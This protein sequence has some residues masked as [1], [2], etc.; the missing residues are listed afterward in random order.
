[1][2]CWDFFFCE[3]LKP[4]E[5]VGSKVIKRAMIGFDST[6]LLRAYSPLHSKRKTRTKH[7]RAFTLSRKAVDVSPEKLMVSATHR[8]TC[9]LAVIKPFF[10]LLTYQIDVRN[11]RQRLRASIHCCTANVIY[12]VVPSIYIYPDTYLQPRR[13]L[14]CTRER[15]CHNRGA[16]LPPLQACAHVHNHFSESRLSNGTRA[17]V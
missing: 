13:H 3:A 15:D 1:M 9:T 7:S 5:V 2:D 14:F 11:N 17:R 12:R 4:K 16:S 6:T 8:P 10:V